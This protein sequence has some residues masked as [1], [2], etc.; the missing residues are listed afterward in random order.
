[1]PISLKLSR[2]DSIAKF[3]ASLLGTSIDE[4][5]TYRIIRRTKGARGALE[6]WPKR[7]AG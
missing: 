1:M 6:L 3:G 7:R 2:L 5:I 4:W